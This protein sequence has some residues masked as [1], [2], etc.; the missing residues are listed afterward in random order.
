[1]V[2]LI[3]KKMRRLG[4]KEM[5]LNWLLVWYNGDGFHEMSEYDMTAA[6]TLGSQYT[7]TYYRCFMEI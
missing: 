7:L 3:H 6:D 5:K 2:F 1:M 4:E